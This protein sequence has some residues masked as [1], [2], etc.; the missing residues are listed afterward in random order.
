MVSLRDER[1]TSQSIR[2]DEGNK[3]A[4][5]AGFFVGSAKDAYFS[6]VSL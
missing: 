1:A 3:K 5:I 2:L 4:R 6:F